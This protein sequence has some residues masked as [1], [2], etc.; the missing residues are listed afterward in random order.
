[1]RS[2]HLQRRQSQQRSHPRPH[3]QAITEDKGSIKITTRRLA[4]VRQRE[5]TIGVTKRLTTLYR[6][7]SRVATKKESS[8]K[9]RY[10]MSGEEDNDEND[11]GHKKAWRA[12]DKFDADRAWANVHGFGGEIREMSGT[13][14]M[15]MGER[16]L[17][18]V[19]N[20]IKLADKKRIS[21]V[22]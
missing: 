15:K 22:D 2:I 4:T 8:K 17:K 18:R 5:T 19:T 16:R 10:M 7:T 11:P 3:K 6:A 12:V 14:S 21:K 13:R 9:D 20:T 1:M